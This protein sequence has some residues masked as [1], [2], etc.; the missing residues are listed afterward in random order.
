MSNETGQRYTFAIIKPHAVIKDLQIQIA[1]RIKGNGF[2]IA[3]Y[4]TTRIGV[5]QAAQLYDEHKERSFYEALISSMTSGDVVLMK[6]VRNDDIDPVT[7][8]RKMMG[9]TNPQLASAGTLRAEFGNTEKMEENAVH[10]SDSAE[11]AQREFG[12]FA[13]VFDANSSN[14]MEI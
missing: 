9:N 1:D 8:F 7:E 2:V 3:Q 12:I 5:E 6:L 4:I 11:S 14:N 10:G 13:D